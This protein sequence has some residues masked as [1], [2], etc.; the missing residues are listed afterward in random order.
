MSKLELESPTIS[1]TNSTEEP[2]PGSGEGAALLPDSEGN[3]TATDEGVEGG[4]GV[5][6]RRDHNGGG[7]S[8]DSEVIPTTP[9]CSSDNNTEM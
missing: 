6:G 3:A 4:S 5:K 8:I 2:I 7:E 9:L 1:A